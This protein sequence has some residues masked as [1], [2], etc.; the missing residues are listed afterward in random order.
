MKKAIRVSLIGLWILSA[1]FFLTRWWMSPSSVGIIP[2]FPES[3][4]A[5]LILGVFDYPEGEHDAVIVVGL[6]LS[7]IIVSLLTLVGWSL[8]HRIKAR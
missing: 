7:L 2:K 1:S 8:W 3:F 6:S 4:W 5:W